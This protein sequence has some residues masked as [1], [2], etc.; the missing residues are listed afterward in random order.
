MSV[1][2][3]TKM[4]EETLAKLREAFLWGCSDDEA[5]LYADI[6]P[7]TLY[8][9]QQDHKEFCDQKPA[10]KGS[11]TM[12]ARRTV[13][14]ALESDPNFAMKYLERKLPEEFGLHKERKNEQQITSITDLV[15]ELS[16]EPASHHDHAT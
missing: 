16:Q 10:W 8:R 7:S 5:C 9:Y 2:R 15:R 4:T 11:P 6:D 1:G 14:E 13:V 12:R 3:P